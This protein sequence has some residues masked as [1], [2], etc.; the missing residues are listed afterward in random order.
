MGEAAERTDAVRVAL[1][2]HGNPIGKGIM[3]NMTRI[4][5][6]TVDRE[7]LDQVRKEGQRIIIEENGSEVA[8]L[9]SIE[10]LRLIE[11]EEDRLDNI[12]AEAALR[13]PGAN[14]PWEKIKER[15][16]AE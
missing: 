1:E 10:D 3:P 4:S 13:E 16:D 2:G 11:S 5:A 8:A 12:A 6:S 9:V 14:I 15:I 7:T